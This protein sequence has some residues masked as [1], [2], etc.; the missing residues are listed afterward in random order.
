MD[1]QSCIQFANAN[2]LCFL[3]TAEDDQ[4]RFVFKGQEFVTLFHDK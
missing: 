1:I 3:A 4:P 2:P